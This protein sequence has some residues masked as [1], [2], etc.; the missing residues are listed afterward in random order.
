MATT[1]LPGLQ[2]ATTYLSGLRMATFTLLAHMVFVLCAQR[3]GEV[4][5]L[6]SSCYKV[7]SPIGLMPLPYDPV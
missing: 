1:Y 2:M 6:S 3:E 4:S 5:G 7:T